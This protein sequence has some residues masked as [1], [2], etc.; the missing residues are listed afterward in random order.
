MRLLIF[1]QLVILIKDFLF[2]IEYVQLV[3]IF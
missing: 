1:A 3:I 2:R